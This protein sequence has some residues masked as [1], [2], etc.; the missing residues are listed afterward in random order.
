MRILVEQKAPGHARALRPLSHAYDR[1]CMPVLENCRVFRCN[2][3]N[4]Q[5]DNVHVLLATRSCKVQINC[6]TLA[7]LEQNNQHIFSHV[8]FNQLGCMVYA[9]L[10]M[11]FSEGV[12]HTFNLLRNQHT[13]CTGNSN[14][15]L[16]SS[17]LH[18]LSSY[19]IRMR[20]KSHVIIYNASVVAFS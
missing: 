5:A 6:V 7:I 12:A 3:M 20:A 4:C 1:H 11:T 9:A 10:Y 14:A 15:T 8:N 13:L 17:T 16:H 18:L 19:S 2:I